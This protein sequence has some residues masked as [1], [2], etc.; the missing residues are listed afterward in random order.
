M[1]RVFVDPPIKKRRES[2]WAFIHFIGKFP[3][4]MLY[5]IDECSKDNRITNRH[6]GYFQRGASHLPSVLGNFINRQR[7]SVLA[8]LSTH[9]IEGIHIVDGSYNTNL[10]DFAFQHSFLNGG[11]FVNR[12]GRS[13]VVL[14]NCRIHDSDEFIDMVQMKG[15]IVVYLPQYSPD[16]SPT[17]VAFSYVKSWLERNRDLAEA[18][19]KLAICQSLLYIT[20]NDARGFFSSSWYQ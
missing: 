19:P 10:Y 14:D 13:I 15:A 18:F 1:E 4:N 9:G 17:E 8:G 16:M 6:Y 5:F 3:I 11:S 2:Q 12:E 20:A 7:V